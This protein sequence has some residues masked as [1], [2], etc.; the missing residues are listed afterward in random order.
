VNERSPNDVIAPGDFK[1]LSASTV[2]PFPELWPSH[3]VA[4]GRVNSVKLTSKH[5]RFNNTIVKALVNLR[6]CWRQEWQPAR[7]VPMHQ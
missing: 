3:S 4:V 7:I 2:C 6:H 1:N 5:N